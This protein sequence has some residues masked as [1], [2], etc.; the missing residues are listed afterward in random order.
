M[1]LLLTRAGRVELARSFQRDIQ[2]AN[3]F[4]Y[5]T[6]GKTDSWIDPD[7]NLPD[8]TVVEEGIDSNAY[9]NQYRRN[10]LFMQRLT[11][12]DTCHLIRRINWDSTGETVYDPYDDAYSSD[13]PAYSEATNLADANFY[14]LTS[15]MRVYLCLDNNNNSKSTTKPEGTGPIPFEHDGDGQ[16][17][18]KWKFMC[19]ISA[20][21]QTKFL[22]NNWMPVRKLT[23]NPQFDVNGIVDAITITSGGSGYSSAPEVV[24]NGDGVDAGATCTINSSGEVDSVTIIS[25]GSGYSFAIVEFVGDGTGAEASVTLGE[26]DAIPALQAAVEAAAIPGTLDRIVITNPGSGYAQN[27]ISVVLVGDGTGAEAEAVVVGGIVTA[28]NITNA[29]SGYT[30]MYVDVTQT[31][32]TGTDFAARAIV[33][34]VE[35]HGANVVREFYSSTVGIVTT[36]YDKDNE[37]LV[38]DN[39]FRQIG[40]AKNFRQYGGTDIWNSR[41]ATA[42]F[43][44]YT[45]DIANFLNTDNGYDSTITTPEGGEFIVS[46][47]RADDT[48]TATYQVYLLP[49]VPSISLDNGD[50]TNTSTGNTITVAD[51]NSIADPEV[52]IA[53]GEVIYIENRAPVTRSVDQAETIKVIVNF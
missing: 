1:S 29:G 44:V 4:Y 34:P 15:D 26:P 6:L 28:I 42:A 50:W 45:D 53:T 14:V 38:L 8:D 12:A 22:D 10:I 30:F 39:D 52:D 19:E 31:A 5:Y 18:Y 21:D 11:S 24:I 37:D 17:G 7:T 43:V 40:L 47:I 35:G 25:E 46:Q 13:N 32:G 9:M 20:A 3:D 16:D 36:I 2:N 27:D 49:V 51:I 48:G 41:T 33:S 23:G